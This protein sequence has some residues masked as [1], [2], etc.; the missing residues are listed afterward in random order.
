[1]SKIIVEQIRSTIGCPK[2]QKKIVAALGLNGIGKT[3]ELGDT[4][5]VRGMIKKISHL[6]RVVEEE[7]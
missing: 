6:V 3:K 4:P 5:A 1:M 7:K 2:T